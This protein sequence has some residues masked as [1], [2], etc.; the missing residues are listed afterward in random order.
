[1]RHSTPAHLHTDWVGWSG[2]EWGGVGWSGVEWGGVGWSS[3]IKL[4]AM[5]AARRLGVFFFVC[6]FCLFFVFFDD[7]LGWGVEC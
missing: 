6:V 3:T 5:G 7:G 4:V 1:M 2:V